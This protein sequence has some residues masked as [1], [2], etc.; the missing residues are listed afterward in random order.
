[1]ADLR[2]ILQEMRDQYGHL[3]P[4]L[5]VAEARDP[6]HPLHS[7]LCWDD[8]EAAE[9]FRLSQARELIRTARVV[10]REAT[11]HDVGVYGRAF[12]AV[13]DPAG[14]RGCV[15]E[16][17]EEVAAD[18][19]SR[20][21]MVRQMNREWQVLHRRYRHFIEFAELVAKSMASP[22]PDAPL[23]G[24]GAALRSVAALPDVGQRFVPDDPGAVTL[25]VRAA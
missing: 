6:G 19:V 24:D 23:D 7:R 12:L 14:S 10:Y 11:S 20:E 5:V 2:S 17:A 25:R 16:P 3:T 8:S 13:P 18:P 4:Q 21:I 15:Y 22:D 9:K 1:M